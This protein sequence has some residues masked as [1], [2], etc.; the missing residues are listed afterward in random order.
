M[1]YSAQYLVFPTTF[2]VMQRKIDYLWNR[3][4]AITYLPRGMLAAILSPPPPTA[5]CG[6]Y[7][8]WLYGK[9][10]KIMHLLSKPVDA[11][12]HVAP[13][14]RGPE[15]PSLILMPCLGLWM[16]A[17]MLPPCHVA[18]SPAPLHHYMTQEEL[19]YYF[20]TSQPRRDHQPHIWFCKSLRSVLQSRRKIAAGQQQGAI[21]QYP[22]LLL[23]VENPK[24]ICQGQRQ[25]FFSLYFCSHN[26]PMQRTSFPFRN[27]VHDGINNKKIYLIAL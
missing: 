23:V 14:P 5:T 7:P 11:G 8:L 15:P 20:G 4:L 26:L 22:H 25:I 21:R 10:K 12:S 27:M 9:A 3:L 13:L 16:L 24:G 17:A 19:H 6:P 1:K 18:L 2:H